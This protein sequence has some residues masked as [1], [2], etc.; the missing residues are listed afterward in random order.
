MITQQFSVF[1]TSNSRNFHFNPG[2]LPCFY[3]NALKSVKNKEKCLLEYIGHLY[4]VQN[5]KKNGC[6]RQ[7]Y[8]MPSEP[9]KQRP[10]FMLPMRLSYKYPHH[11]PEQLVMFYL[12]LLNQVK[13]YRSIK[14][15]FSLHIKRST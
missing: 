6:H 13:S 2:N 5:G 1:K 7:P 4:L 8:E 12:G 9:M 15:I 14:N 11:F 10:H 3:Q